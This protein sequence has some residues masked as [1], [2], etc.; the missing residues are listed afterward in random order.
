MKLLTGIAVTLLS[1]NLFADVVESLPKEDNLAKV[2]RAVGTQLRDSNISSGTTSLSA[3]QVKG[4]GNFAALVKKAFAE[5]F[6]AQQDVELPSDAKLNVVIGKFVDGDEKNGD[7]YK[8][9]DALLESND[10]N[11]SNKEIRESSARSLWAVLRKLPVSEKTMIGHVKV[12]LKDNNSDELRT[13]QYFL[14]MN[15]D[16]KVVQFYTVEGTM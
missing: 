11:P 4:S 15:G 9:T 7:V 1:L 16:E 14:L 5:E 6:K 13:I 10:Y 8:M 3:G 2:A 12:R